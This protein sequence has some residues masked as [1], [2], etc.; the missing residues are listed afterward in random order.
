MLKERQFLS[1]DE[2]YLE[3]DLTVRD[4]RANQ[5]MKKSKLYYW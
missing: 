3:S 1:F 2:G 4:Y 5:N